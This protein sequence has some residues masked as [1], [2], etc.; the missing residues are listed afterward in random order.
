M[1]DTSVIVIAAS[2][3]IF[4]MQDFRKMRGRFKSGKLDAGFLG[5]DEWSLSK[6]QILLVCAL[7]RKFRQQR[8]LN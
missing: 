7:A 6:R 1:G 8:C 4:A 3:L 5:H 2:D